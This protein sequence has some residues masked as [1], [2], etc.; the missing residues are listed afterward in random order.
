MLTPAQTEQLLETSPLLH[1]I[2]DPATEVALHDPLR[3]ECFM[4]WLPR[5]GPTSMIFLVETIRQWNARPSTDTCLVLDPNTFAPMVGVQ[6]MAFRKMLSRLVRFNVLH[7][8]DAGFVHIN[9][10]LPRLP[11]G[12]LRRHD[13]EYRRAYEQY[14]VW[15]TAN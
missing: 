12:E 1:V 4:W 2:V 5:L 6:T 14:V 7:M 9:R 8:D 10:W 13:D 15:C 3:W 11:Q